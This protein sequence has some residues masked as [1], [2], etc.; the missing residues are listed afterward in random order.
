MFWKALWNLVLAKLSIYIAFGGVV[1]CVG[2][3]Y[4]RTRDEN[5]KHRGAMAIAAIGSGVLAAICGAAYLIAPPQ[6][7]PMGS[8]EFRQMDEALWHPLVDSLNR[9]NGDK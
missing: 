4:I 9:A 8:E 3:L 5:A 2:L 6:V 1:L 7:P